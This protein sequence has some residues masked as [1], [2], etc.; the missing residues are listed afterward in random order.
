MPIVRSIEGDAGL[1]SMLAL[2]PHVPDASNSRMVW[3]LWM[4]GFGFVTMGSV[5]EGNAA[6]QGLDGKDKGGRKLKVNEARPKDD[7]GER[8]PPGSRR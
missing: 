3:M 4:R 6:I 5:S 7:R 8:P 2:M 1:R